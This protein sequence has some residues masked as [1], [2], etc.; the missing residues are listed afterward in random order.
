MAHLIHDRP[1]VVMSTGV[2]GQKLQMEKIKKGIQSAI[3]GASMAHTS[4]MAATEGIMT[5]DTFPKLMSKEFK[6]SVGTYRMGGW[7]KGAGMIHPNMATMLSSVFTDCKISKKL[8]DLA[9]KNA[10]CRSFNAISIDGDTSTN[11]TFAVF[12][13]GAAVMKEIETESSLEFQEFQSNL[14]YF[15]TELA[16]LIV[17]DGE[18]ATKFV[19][20]KVTVGK[21]SHEKGAKTFEDARQVAN[22]IVKSPLVKTAIYGKDANWGRIVCAVG[23]S[24]VEVDPSTVNLHFSCLDKSKYLH[25]FKNGEPYEINETVAS[26][27]LEME[28]LLIHVDLGSGSESLSMYTCD[29]SHEYISINANYRS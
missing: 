2:I 7:A 25:L 15:A 27:I 18:G 13:N 23:Y 11:D 28:D 4:W 22:T 19:E 26:E 3:D 1:A 8:L 10:A 24:G 17:R 29:M 5:T 12:A 9:V 14:T 6:T 21:G 16:K 20:V